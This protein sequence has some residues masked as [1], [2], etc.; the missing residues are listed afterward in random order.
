MVPDCEGVGVGLGVG[1]IAKLAVS[2]IGPF[3]IKVAGL[4]EPLK[5][6]TPLPIQPVNVKPLFG[7]AEMV[8]LCPA[9][10][11]LLNGLTVPPVPAFIVKKYRV[12]KLAV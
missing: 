5:D 4:P 12:V 8:T 3:M 10:I 9:L 6:P 1:F 7:K 2:V 11:Q